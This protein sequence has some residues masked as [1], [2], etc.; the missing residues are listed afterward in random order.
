MLSII[1]ACV[2]TGPKGTA[3]PAFGVLWLPSSREAK[4]LALSL[5]SRLS[6]PALLVDAVTPLLTMRFGF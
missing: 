4:L 2:K 3:A 1:A 5:L 6:C